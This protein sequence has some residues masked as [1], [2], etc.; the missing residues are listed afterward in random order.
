MT[1]LVLAIVGA[2]VAAAAVGA[3]MWQ[4]MLLRKQLENADRV[5]RA[6]FYQGVMS[7]F[8]QLDF[9]FIENHSWRPYF[10]DNATAS[11]EMLKQ[12]TA[13]LAEYI[14]DV[15][16]SCTA[17]EDALPELTGDWDDFFNYLYRNSPAI[18]QYWASFSHLYPSRVARALVG[19][20]ARPKQWPVISSSDGE[21]QGEAQRSSDEH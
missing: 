14:V 17:A 1:A 10:Y 13:A 5:R 3:A 11:E 15:A 7:L 6:S 20:S 4:G 16:E 19:P 9:I 18:R 8:I 12:Q 2:L 21:S